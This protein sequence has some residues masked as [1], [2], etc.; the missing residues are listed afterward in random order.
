MLVLGRKVGERV[1][2]PECQVTITVLRIAGKKIRL[3]ISAPEGV[4]V[5]REEIWRRLEER[6]CNLAAK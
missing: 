1:V 4:S 2:L 6:L 3:G 5:H